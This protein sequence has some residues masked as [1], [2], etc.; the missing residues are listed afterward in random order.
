MTSESRRG[1]RGAGRGPRTDR[2][3]HRPRK[4]YGQHFL[5]PAWAEKL[6]K[7]IDPRPEDRFLEIGPGP[8]A[9]TLRLAPRVAHLTAIEIDRDI[10]AALT[11]RVPSNVTLVEGDFLEMDLGALAAAGPLRVAGN[12]PY[13]ISSPIMFR[14]LEARERMHLV[15]ATLMLQRE[16]AER[17]EAGPGS[18]DYG[19]LS[20]MVAM[21]AD[22]RRLLSLPPGAFRPPPKVHSAVIRLTFRPSPV[23]I[24]DR[25]V[26]DAMVRSVFTQRRKTL[27][28]AL[29]SFAGLRGVDSGTA[30]REAGIDAAR[31]AETLDLSELAR[32]ADVLAG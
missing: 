31:R 10:V 26:F 25:E 23:Q 19:V 21:G 20:I 3:K 4:R 6:V 2:Q 14:L 28:N 15:D 9:L 30:L 22:V 17:I 8:G 1:P 7:A 29:Q 24:R 12:L 27:L 32:L 5:E 18:R 13:N 16:V 11:P